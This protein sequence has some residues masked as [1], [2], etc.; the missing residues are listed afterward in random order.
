MKGQK[1][2][3]ELL[4]RAATM[5][6]TAVHQYLLHAHVLDDWGLTGLAAK[7]RDEMQEELGHCDRFIRRMVF[8]EGDPDV[9]TM[10]E[11]ARAGS[12]KEMFEADL[13]DEIEA[14]TFYTQA[15]RQAM[16]A[17][18]LGTRDLFA[19]ITLDEEGHID[20][21]ESQLGLL[22]RLGEAGYYQLY[23]GTDSEG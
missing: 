6:F 5:E 21:L 10:G 15:A 18:D 4:Q 19:S 13:A 23:A 17:G 14:R 22:E 7:M 16:D 9:Q 2:I 12:L 20:W 1:E 11:V 8:L 3:L